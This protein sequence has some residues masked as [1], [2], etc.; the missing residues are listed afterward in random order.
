M[1]VGNGLTGSV[2][3]DS[4]RRES[5]FSFLDRS[6][7]D[8][9]GVNTTTNTVLHFD[10]EFGDNVGFESLIFLEIF[11][12][13]GIDDVSDVET[14]DGFVF[15]AQATAVDADDGLD[16]ASVVFVTTVVSPLDGHVVNS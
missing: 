14:L 12:R 5:V 15:G 3:L 1:I 2:S 10:V 8:D 4:G 7:F 11:F 13:G 16:I 6:H 9:S